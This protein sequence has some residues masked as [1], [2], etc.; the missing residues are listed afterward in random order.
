ME[1]LSSYAASFGRIARI[2]WLYRLAG[3][4]LACA[5]FGMLAD[6]AVGPMGSALFAAVFLWCAGAATIQRLHD[7]GRSGH[8]LLAMLVP[9]LGPLWLLWQCLRRGQ[10]GDN[11]YGHQPMSRLDYLRVDISK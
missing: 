4:G 6:A 7:I 2:T 3:L 9:I 1:F 8:A 11:F 5:A 10:P